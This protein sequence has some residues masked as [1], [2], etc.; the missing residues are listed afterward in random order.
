MPTKKKHFG[1]PPKGAEKLTRISVQLHPDELAAV[2]KLAA[3]DD[4]SDSYIIRRAV[5]QML[6]LET[7]PPCKH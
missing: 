6:G 7:R 5:R 1:R 3:E 4:R 2:H